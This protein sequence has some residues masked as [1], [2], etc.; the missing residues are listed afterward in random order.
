MN[1][2]RDEKELEEKAPVKLLHTSKEKLTKIFSNTDFR[3]KV[4]SLQTELSTSRNREHTQVYMPAPRC[5]TN[6]K[7]KESE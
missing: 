2:Y 6:P 1:T 3:N 5:F 4:A 7:Q